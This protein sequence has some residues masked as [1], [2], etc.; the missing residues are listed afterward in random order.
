MSWLRH[1]FHLTDPQF[2]AIERL[3]GE[4][5][6]ACDEHCRAIREARRR[7]EALRTERPTSLP[8]IEASERRVAELTRICETSLERHLEQVAALMSPEDGRCYL[9]TMRPLLARFNHAGA[10]DLIFSATANAHEH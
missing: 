8:A 4:F 3:H 6:G 10:P 9:D 2:A 1:E 7:L 5:T